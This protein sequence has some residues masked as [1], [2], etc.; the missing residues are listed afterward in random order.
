MSVAGAAHTVIWSRRALR[1]IHH[2]TEGIPRRINLLCDRILMTAFVRETHHVRA[3]IVQWSAQELASPWQAKRVSWL[4]RAALG[5]YIG[6]GI[7]ALLGGSVVAWLSVQSSWYPRV[8][9]Q[10]SALTRGAMS[11]LQAPLL[12]PVNEP[13]SSVAPM[14]ATPALVPPSSPQEADMGLAQTL[15]RV[16]AQ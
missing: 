11:P 14:L 10:V 16:K 4:R 7:L 12:L 1:L 3:P 8:A 9:D 6:L 13:A 2:Y 5:G 15:W